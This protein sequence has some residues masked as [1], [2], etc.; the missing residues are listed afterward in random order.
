M[1]IWLLIGAWRFS[2]PSPVWNSSARAVIRLH[3]LSAYGH[4]SALYSLHSTFISYVN[5]PTWKSSL[6]IQILEKFPHHSLCEFVGV[7][8]FSSQVFSSNTQTLHHSIA[9]ARSL[10]DGFGLPLSNVLTASFLAFSS[11]SKTIRGAYVSGCLSSPWF[12]VWIAY[13]PLYNTHNTRTVMQ[14]VFTSLPLFSSSDFGAGNTYNDLSVR[15][16][17]RE[18]S[19]VIKVQYTFL[20]VLAA[21]YRSSWRNSC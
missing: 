3:I 9:I 5:N 4:W 18:W 21:T 13:R 20:V 17:P 1:K 6:L 7:S 14:D 2:L 8:I 12:H 10:P 11:G 16:C 19:H 15:I